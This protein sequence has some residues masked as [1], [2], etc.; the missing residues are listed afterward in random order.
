MRLVKIGRSRWFRVLAL[1]PLVAGTL[2]ALPPSP[3]AAVPG[4][5]T[6]APALQCVGTD[7]VSGNRV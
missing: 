7:G 1:A 2:T 4:G 5:V 6:A 3:A